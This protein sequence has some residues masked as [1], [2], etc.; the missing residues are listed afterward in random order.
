M[1]IEIKEKFAV[2]LFSIILPFTKRSKCSY[3]DKIYKGKSHC[4]LS[5]KMVTLFPY[6]NGPESTIAPGQ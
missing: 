1:S 6:L 5:E 2:V 4:F 3:Y